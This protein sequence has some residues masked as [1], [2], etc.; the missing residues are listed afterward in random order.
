MGMNGSS[1]SPGHSAQHVVS[2]DEHELW[3]SLRQSGQSAPTTGKAVRRA[4]ELQIRTEL[5][6]TA[7]TISECLGAQLDSV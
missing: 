4:V 1:Q 3:F 6:L 2:V 5:P 7:P